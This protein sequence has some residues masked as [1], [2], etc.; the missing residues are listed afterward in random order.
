MF[1]QGLQGCIQSGL[2]NETLILGIIIFSIIL[3]VITPKAL[4][5]KSEFDM[6]VLSE[7]KCKKVT[8]IGTPKE[9]GTKWGELN[10]ITIQEHF[11]AF[12]TSVMDKGLDKEGMIE[13]SQR[14]N[15]IIEEI[16]PHWHEEDNAVAASAGVDQE[17]YSSY[18]A[19][20]YRGLFFV[21][22]YEDCTS[23]FSVGKASLDGAPM[24]HKNR[25]NVARSQAAYYKKV[26]VDGKDLYSYISIGDVSDTGLMMMVNEKGLAG[27]ADTGGID[28]NNP[29]GK[30]IMNPYILRYIAENA[31][32]CEEAIAILTEMVEKRWYA[33]GDI[34]THWLF[35]DRFGTGVRVANNSREVVIFENTQNG[36]DAT[37]PMI[38]FLL[39]KHNGK[40]TLNVLNELSRHATICLPKTISAYSVKIDE[41]WPDILTRI[42]ISMGRPSDTVYIPI[43]MSMTETPKCLADGTLWDEAGNIGVKL[44]N[45]S[46]A[47]LRL[48]KSK[49]EKLEKELADIT[50]LAEIEARRLLE[51]G[52]VDEARAL[53]KSVSHHNVTKAFQTFKAME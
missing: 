4:A 32:T 40:V 25:D 3:P 11:D 24:I 49:L 20:K 9:I 29:T 12:I 16:A 30:G 27:L 46:G 53:L 8:L 51:D 1:F 13:R 44:Q 47:K 36:I 22:D 37:K 42:D 5:S 7:Y 41:N 26:I 23:Y 10:S 28:E 33:G 2:K 19:G 14:H 15:Q 52:K 48:F 45:L 39:E 50:V 17:L 35:V 6:S 21:E 43:F 38:R 31:E 18:L 34:G